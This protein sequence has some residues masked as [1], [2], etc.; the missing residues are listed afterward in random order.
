MIRLAFSGILFL[1]LMGLFTRVAL[2]FELPLEAESFKLEK[3]WAVTDYGNFPSQPDFWSVQKI[4]ADASDTPAFAR[5]EIT[6]PADGK[7]N[8][9]VRFESS[10]GFNSIFRVQI[11]QQGTVKAT[12]DFG[13]QG[14][15]KWF[16]F[17]RGELVQG[18]W[19]WHNTD[20]VYQGMTAELSAGKATIIISKDKNEQPAARRIIDLLYLTDDLTI[21]PGDDWTWYGKTPRPAILSRFTI[22]VFVRAKVLE[23]AG[24]VKVITGFALYGNHPYSPRETWYLGADGIS[25]KAPAADKVLKAGAQTAWQ[26][27]NIYSVMV[28][29]I[30][31]SQGGNA[32]V[33]LEIAMRSPKNIVKTVV[34]GPGKDEETVIAAIGMGKYEK[35]LLGR[36]KALTTEEM[37]RKQIDL[38]VKYTPPGKPAHNILLTGCLREPYLALQ[39]ELGAACGLNGQAYGSSPVIYGEKPAVSGYNTSI[40]SLSVQNLHLTPAGYQ[41]DY[42]AIEAQYR[43]AAD[44]MEK[45]LGR[46]L[47]LHIKL[48]EET[49]P[50]DIDTMLGWPSVKEQFIAYLKGEGLTLEGAQQDKDIYY[51]Q[52]TRFRS[53][54]FARVNAGAT[55]LLEKIF[56]A[57]SY[58]HSGSIYPTTG[59][60]P[61]LARGDDLFQLFRER[62][63]SEYS[64]EMSW[65][66]GGTPDYIGPQTQ[67][68][69]GALARCLSKYHDCSMGAY[70]IADGN[71]GYTGDFVEMGSYP[72]FSQGMKWLHYY[73]FGWPDGCSFIG[74]PDIL[75]GIKRV[76][77]NIGMVEDELLAAK[78]VPAKIAIGWSSTTDVWDLTRKPSY[79][80][81]PGNCVYPQERHNL[82]LML[83]HLQQP[84]DLLGEEDLA[85]GYLKPYSVF[86][87][88]GDHLRPE[89]AGALRAWVEAGGTLISVAGGGLFDQYNRPLDTLK[90]VF[91]IK[92]AVLVKTVDALRPKLDLLHLQPMDR[93]QGSGR[94]AGKAMDVY[95]YRQSFV[96][97]GGTVIGTYRNGE[98]AVVEHAFGKGRAIALGALPGP[99]YMK[100]AIPLRPFGRGGDGGELSQFFPTQFD[101]GIGGMIGSLLETA[102]PVVC[103]HPLVEAVLLARKDGGFVIP[104]MNFSQTKRSALTVRLRL[105]GEIKSVK[106]VFSRVKMR[107]EGTDVLVDVPALDKFDCL[108]VQ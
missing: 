29:E 96:A 68:Y 46:K 33:S 56:P 71:R 85:D 2:A 5:K 31:V 23:G 7:Y 94:L 103:S 81:S 53:L 73:E 6:L 44:D 26:Q 3:G 10:V 70:F 9:W 86:F 67:S 19:D 57:G 58:V 99:A 101:Q 88:V 98:A 82:Y 18:A 83:R 17:G 43:K 75:K 49:G 74:Y 64:S 105:P 97:D 51:Y 4:V 69:E 100:P 20:Y 55:R 108:I 45:A 36:D 78:V 50:P 62:G 91:G 76:N 80:N 87:L 38:L 90:P 37:L 59:G 14:D 84:V 104:L 79:V 61:T 63:V 95:G 12:G 22:P 107:R 41:G 21:K 66:L 8:L 42:A 13:R 52:S 106:S 27:V 25:S 15:K 34:V 48:L 93:L 35:G 77:R 28:P 11:V 65:S 40:G 89:A 47:P 24:S 39:A 32:K 60:A 102:S 1:C 16:P 92:D 72:M 30:V 54:M